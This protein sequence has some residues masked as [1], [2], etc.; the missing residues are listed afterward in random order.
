MRNGE[1]LLNQNGIEKERVKG[2]D[3]MARPLK[4][5]DR[6]QFEALCSIWCTQEEICLILNVTD[7][8]LN[9]WCKRTYK[10]SFSEIYKKFSSF[11]KMSLRRKQQ[12]VALKGNV[13]MLIFLGKQKLGQRDNPEESLDQED[14][15]S[16]FKDAGLDDF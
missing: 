6:K 7:K 3:N 10:V 8:T 4:E 5:L 11:G 12:E 15:E 9:K 13:P 2:G 1:H 14:T 16:Y